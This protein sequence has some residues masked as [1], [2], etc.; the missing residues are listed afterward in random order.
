MS[1]VDDVELPTERRL[2]LA[3]ERL[4]AARGVD[5]V[6][7]RAVMAAADANIASVHYHFGSKDALVQALISERSEAISV[8]RMQLLDAIEESGRPTPRL[9]AEAFIVPVAEAV[10]SGGGDWVA[11]IAGLLRGNH[12]A[13]A[14]VT[15]GFVP[16]ARRFTG[17]LQQLYPEMPARTIRF[18]L[19]QSMTL[20]FQVLGNRENVDDMLELSG[21]GLTPDE[22]L[23]ELTDLVTAILAGPPPRD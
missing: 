16:Q 17:L 9:L 23:D 8:R 13:L 11:V 18:R 20:T 2:I 19:T 7:L 1:G 14:A 6:S 10:R 5:A 15:A 4:F 12:P 3:A 21:P 22:V